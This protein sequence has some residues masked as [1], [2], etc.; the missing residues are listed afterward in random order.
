MN[1]RYKPLD[2]ATVKSKAQLND[3]SKQGVFYLGGERRHVTLLQGP[4]CIFSELSL[5]QNKALWT[6]AY[7]VQHNNLYAT[8]V[9]ADMELL[10]YDKG[11]YSRLIALLVKLRFIHVVNKDMINKGDR[12]YMINPSLVW[13]GYLGHR[14]NALHN[15]NVCYHKLPVLY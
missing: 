12:L 14:D 4:D 1:D 9:K 2:V 3:A 15:W 8:S 5:S 13:F 6:L 11:Q 10:G 7:Q